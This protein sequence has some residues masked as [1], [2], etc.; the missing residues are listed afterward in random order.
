MPREVIVNWDDIRIFL[1]V[2]RAGQ[3]LG[4]ARRLS[5]NHATVARRLTALEEALGA[6]LFDRS[7]N[8]CYLSDDGAAFLPHAERME[9]EMLAAEAQFGTHT[10]EVTGTVRI[11]APDG[12]GVAYLA[13]RLSEL[14]R[15]HPGLTLQL[16]PMPRSFS[17]SRREADIVI[18]IERPDHGRLVAAKLTD[19]TLG[20]YASDAYLDQRGVPA[21]IS[22]LQ[23]HDLVGLVEDLAY[24]PAL[25]YPA[26]FIKS[27]PARFEVASAL[28]QVEA[29][30]A[31]AGIGILHGFLV[32]DRP[33]LCRI[34]PEVVVSRAYWTVQHESTRSLRPISLVLQ[35]LRDTLARDRALFT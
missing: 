22:E 3:I 10:M 5:L 7:T 23:T 33:G 2:A 11:G 6:R 26:D 15:Q 35:F 20:L 8:G 34:L 18:T 32:K 27:W 29:V 25:N 24:S 17:L 9:T 1:S 4:A 12:F 30:A 16:V 19:Y 13:P 14:T 28:G 31:G 21:T